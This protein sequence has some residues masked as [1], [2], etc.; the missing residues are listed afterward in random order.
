MIRGPGN[1]ILHIFNLNSMGSF[2]NNSNLSSATEGPSL[3]IV[4]FIMIL[5]LAIAASDDDIALSSA[6]MYG[7]F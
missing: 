4:N 6:F 1:A 2:G 5:F 3:L 7:R